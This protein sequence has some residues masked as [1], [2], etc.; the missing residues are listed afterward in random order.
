M[1]RGVARKV[2]L[3]VRI[4][5]VLKDRLEQ[6]AAAEERTVS[7]ICEMLLRQGAEG[8]RKEGAKYLQRFLS[9]Q[10]KESASP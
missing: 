3:G 1:M 6:I 4:N 2:F 8:Y 7:Q 10:K 9:R 5:P